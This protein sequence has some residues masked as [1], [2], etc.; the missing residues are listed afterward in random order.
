MSSEG[1]TGDR[2][3]SGLVIHLEDARGEQRLRAALAGEVGLELGVG[4]HPSRIPAVLEVASGAESVAVVRD[5]ESRPG[6]QRVD[7]V[8]V[9][10]GEHGP[11]AGTNGRVAGAQAPEEDRNARRSS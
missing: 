9:A 5:L 11:E 7:V 4:R 2:Q 8:F 1:P 6:V 3:V 10:S